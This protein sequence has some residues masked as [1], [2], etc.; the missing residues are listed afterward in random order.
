MQQFKVGDKAK[1]VHMP[2]KGKHL[3]HEVVRVIPIG[4][5]G[6]EEDDVCVVTE[7]GMMLFLKESQLTK[8]S[9]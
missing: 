9:N 3:L 7:T 6:V 2:D 1:I 5:F 4:G 8:L